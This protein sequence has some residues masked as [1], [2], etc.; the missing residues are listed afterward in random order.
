[1]TSD[2]D[3]IRD[4]EERFLAEALR[5]RENRTNTGLLARGVVVESFALEGSYPR[6]ELVMRFCTPRRGR[7]ERR[8]PIWDV[9]QSDAEGRP[10]S[11]LV[12]Y[13]IDIDIV[14]LT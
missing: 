7:D 4:T 11:L 9:H 3:I 12:W 8:Y 10:V 13:D 14:E 2:A 6:T 5:A 1:M